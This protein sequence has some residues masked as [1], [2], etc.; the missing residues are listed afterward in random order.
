KT[1]IENAGF[2]VP[3]GFSDSDLNKG[4]SRLFSD[5]FCL[6]YLH[7]ITMHGLLGHTTSLT[8]SARKDLRHFYDSCGND[9]KKMY[10]LTTELLQEKGLFQR[11]PYFY[12]EAHP[13]YISGPKFLDA[14]LG[15]KRQLAATEIIAL[16]FIMKKKILE[17][18]LSI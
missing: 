8:A 11:D 16:S 18:T 6:H 1:F 15:D 7:I 10:H 13:E 3:I 4:A 9:G 12:P 2:P 5:T 17:K 14:F